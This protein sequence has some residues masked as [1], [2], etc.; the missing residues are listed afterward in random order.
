MS[1]VAS[2]VLRPAVLKRRMTKTKMRGN[3]R[4]KVMLET[5]RKYEVPV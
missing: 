1:S 2:V 3:T 4:R 5:M